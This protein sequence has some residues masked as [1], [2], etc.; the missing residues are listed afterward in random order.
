MPED[1][2]V[3]ENIQV[4]QMNSTWL[5]SMKILSL[6]FKEF[7]EVMY[8]LLPFDIANLLEGKIPRELDDVCGWEAILLFFVGG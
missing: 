3:L 8:D 1:E 6:L 7:F 5:G 4:I 2:N